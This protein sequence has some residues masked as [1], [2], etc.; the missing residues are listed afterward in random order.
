MN[1]N[2]K[3]P[4]S[5][6]NAFFIALHFEREHI[7]PDALEMP[8]EI[9]IKMVDKDFPRVQVNLRNKTKE[10]SPLKLDLELVGLFDYVGNNPE[11]DRG[12]INDFIREKGLHMLWPY[13]SQMIKMVTGQM[14]MS[15]LDTRTPLFFDVPY[16]K[17]AEK[18]DDSKL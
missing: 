5:L 13:I 2:I 1:Q 6:A 15:P 7:L 12:L 9:Q 3:Y 16:V 8:I 10:Q 11:R 18:T 14:G 17:E 4:F